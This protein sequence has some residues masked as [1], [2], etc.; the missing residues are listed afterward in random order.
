MEEDTEDYIC[1]VFDE[2]T[3][4]D[5]NRK[6]SFC[7]A[8]VSMNFAFTSVDHVVWHRQVSGRL[9]PCPKCRAVIIDWLHNEK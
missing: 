7:G 9:L 5:L 8:F 2:K 1:H 4:K 3:S 6:V